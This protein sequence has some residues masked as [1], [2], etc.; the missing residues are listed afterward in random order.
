MNLHVK[1][2]VTSYYRLA[3]LC[4]KVICKMMSTSTEVSCGCGQNQSQ[5]QIDK[6]TSI[7]LFYN[8]QV[9]QCRIHFV[10]G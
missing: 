3:E 10:H 8:I 9:Q 4:K 7:I 6:F 2:K 1:Q 5:S